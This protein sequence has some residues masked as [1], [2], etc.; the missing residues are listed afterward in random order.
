MNMLEVKKLKK[1]YKTRLQGNQVEALKDVNFE[2]KE[3]E[4]VA[5]MGGIRKWKNYIA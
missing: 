3:K 2:V 4:Y 5:I 1:I